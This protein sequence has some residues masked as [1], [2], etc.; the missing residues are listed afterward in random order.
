VPL[1]GGRRRERG[2]NQSEILAAAAARVVGARLD[3]RLLARRRD[4]RPQARLPLPAR[5]PNVRGA[6][7]F[8]RTPY[9]ETLAGRLV[10]V[11]DVVTSGATVLECVGALEAAGARDVHV[12]AL[13]KA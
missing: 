12:L 5:A 9:H 3:S 7:R 4:T 1:H 2:Y 10:L 6:F 8:A 11:D 13:V